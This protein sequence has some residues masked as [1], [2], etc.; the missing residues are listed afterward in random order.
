MKYKNIVFDFG[1]VLATFNEN[2]ILSKYCNQ[3]DL[4]T[5]R[6]CIYEEWWE[7]DAHVYTQEE[8]EALVIAKTPTHLHEAV[9]LF[10][11]D[12]YKQLEPI[13]E[14]WQLVRELKA[15]G[16]GLYILSNAPVVFA[17]NARELYPIA[18]LFDGAVYSAAIRMAKPHDN[19]Y[20]YLF[21][22]YQLEPATCLFID[23]KKINVDASIRNGMEAIEFH[24]DVEQIKQV[25]YR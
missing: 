7:Y 12:W 11:R 16:Y 14:M 9:R 21:H 15:A 23:D 22:T 10:F 3:D 8:Y 24:G 18:T 17:Q 13:E 2:K 1:N 25:I 6:N 19:I 5:L 4:L 20:Q